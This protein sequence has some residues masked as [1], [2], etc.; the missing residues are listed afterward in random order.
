[1]KYARYEAGGKVGYGSVEGDRITPIEGDLWGE[2]RPSGQAMPL[3]SVRLLAPVV[4]NIILA[5]ALNYPSHIGGQIPSPRPEL[6]VKSN[7]TLADP[8]DSIVLPAGCE[9]VDY[10]GEVVAV[11]GRTCKKVTAEEAMDY[12]FGFTC[13]ND[14]S[15]RPW[16]RGDQQWFRGKSA[17]GH[18]PIGPWIVTRD[19]LKHDDMWL[20][21]RLNGKEVQRCNTGEM[22]NNIP[23][24]IAFLSQTC[25]LNPG[26]IIFTGTSGQPLALKDGDV[27]EVDVQGIGILRN[28]FIDDPVPSNWT[29]RRK[30]ER[31]GRVEAAA[32]A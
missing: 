10:E 13:G 12:V 26:D 28:S 15:C 30:E 11:I 18:G 29:D 8:E 21:T 31:P 25:T 1:M 32:R 16:Q 2:R 24:T 6:F 3:N 14:V 20:S 7:N 9:R 19:E 23:D 5:V 17:D 4:P 22:I 27:V